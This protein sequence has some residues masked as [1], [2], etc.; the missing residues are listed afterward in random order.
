MLMIFFNLAI[1]DNKPF[2]RSGNPC[3]PKA[4]P[5]PISAQEAGV[6]RGP[7]MGL[8]VF[9]S[10]PEVHGTFDTDSTYYV[11]SQDQAKVNGN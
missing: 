5:R 8:Q 3:L 1:R 9:S 7:E 6:S 4:P 10:P 2:T 11:R